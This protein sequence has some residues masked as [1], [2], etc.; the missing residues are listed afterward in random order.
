MLTQK[1]V[2]ALERAADDIEA[3]PVDPRDQDAAMDRIAKTAIA[4]ILRLLADHAAERLARV[5]PSDG[6]A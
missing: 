3:M 4:A 6:G 5:K 1:D 2:Q